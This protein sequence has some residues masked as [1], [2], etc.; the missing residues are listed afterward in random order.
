MNATRQNRL[1]GPVIALRTFRAED[2]KLHLE[3]QRR[4]LRWLIDQGINE[5]NGVIMGAG[6]GGEGYF[7]TTL[8]RKRDG[9]SGNVDLTASALAPDRSV[10]AGSKLN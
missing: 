3:K 8:S 4:H 2:G 9:F 1:V 10:R 6:G 7:V 5:G